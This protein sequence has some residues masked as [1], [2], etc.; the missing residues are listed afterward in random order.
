MKE[1]YKDYNTEFIELNLEI[2]S[3]RRDTLISKFA[4]TSIENQKLHIFCQLRN[5][6]QDMQLRNLPTYRTTKVNTERF[7]KSSILHMQ[8]TL[9]EDK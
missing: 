7:Y 5:T 3:S 6:K 9:H 4:K 2:L 1:R 8:R